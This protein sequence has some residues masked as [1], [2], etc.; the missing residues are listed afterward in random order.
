MVL[1]AHYKALG[2]VVG[3]ITLFHDACISAMKLVGQASTDVVR[4]VV[5]PGLPTPHS[6][7]GTGGEEYDIKPLLSSYKS[8]RG[9]TSI[10]KHIG[11]TQTSPLRTQHIPVQLD[12]L[13]KMASCFGHD[14]EEAKAHQQY[15]SV[16]LAG[17]GLARMILMD[18]HGCRSK[19]HMK[20]SF[21]MR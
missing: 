8:V 12:D 4:V 7:S 3:C 11:R 17:S 1:I 10:G 2:V 13:C 6:S 5:S 18:W 16:R 21:P 14:S 15:H 19:I 20:R 9:S